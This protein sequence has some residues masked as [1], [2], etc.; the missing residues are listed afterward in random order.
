MIRFVTGSRRRRDELVSLKILYEITVL[1]YMKALKSPAE[2]SENRSRWNN[3]QMM[4]LPEGA[5][6]QDLKEHLLCTL[7]A[8]GPFFPHFIVKRAHRMPL[9]Q[10]PQRAPPHTF[11][12]QLLNFRD[13][14]LVLREARKVEELC[15]E[16]A[17]FMLFSDYFI[18]TQRLHRTFDH[19]KAQLRT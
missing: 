5:E 16:N 11:I 15:F 14:D 2:D 18:E 4:G 9:V 8:Q 13:Q 10:G 12:F 1:L 6:G 7:F 3:L 19:V 17:K